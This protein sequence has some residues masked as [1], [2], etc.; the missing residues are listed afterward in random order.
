MMLFVCYNHID[1][2]D[3]DYDVCYDM[4]VYR[5][6]LFLSNTYMIDIQK[7]VMPKLKS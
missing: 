4:V 6:C 5:L 1:D 2:D 7:K 3:D